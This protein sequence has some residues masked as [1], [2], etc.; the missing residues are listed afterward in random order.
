MSNLLLRKNSTTVYFAYN[1]HVN[2][3]FNVDAQSIECK[4][5]SSIDGNDFT[6]RHFILPLDILDEKARHYSVI[7]VFFCM[8][9][10]SYFKIFRIR[11]KICKK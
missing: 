3:T 7:A 11:N 6:A 5:V 2:V 1:E 4:I 8:I 10:I 9:Q